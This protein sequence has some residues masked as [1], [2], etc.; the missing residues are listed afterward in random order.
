MTSLSCNEN[1]MASFNPFFRVQDHVCHLIGSIVPQTGESPA[2]F[3]LLTIKMYV[4]CRYNC[5]WV[6]GDIVSSINHLLVDGDH[7]VELFKLHT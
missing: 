5:W 3:T 6:D 4:P 2:K 1:T 7:N